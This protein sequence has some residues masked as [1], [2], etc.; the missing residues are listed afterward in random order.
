M[1]F[2]YSNLF[3]ELA[4][5]TRKIVHI[6]C[7]LYLC[8]VIQSDNLKILSF[9]SVYVSEDHQMEDKEG[10]SSS[11]SEVV[12]VRNVVGMCKCVCKCVF[13]CVCKWGPSDGG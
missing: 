11:E 10:Y 12:F 8:N 2:S 6:L 9:L 3:Y 4:L 1:E 5:R 7:F 13:K